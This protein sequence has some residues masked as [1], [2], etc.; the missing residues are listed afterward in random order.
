MKIVALLYLAIY[1]LIVGM[2]AGWLAWVVLGSSK[3]LKRDR[4]PNWTA[5]LGLGVLGSFVGGLGMS[6]LRG[7]GLAL[8]PSGMIASAVGA[9]VVVATY[10]VLRARSA[11]ARRRE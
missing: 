8:H 4:K 1:L 3:A 2:A 5:L 11:Q 10:L 7:E 6:L 9:T